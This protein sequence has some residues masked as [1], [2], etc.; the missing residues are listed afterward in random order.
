MI[1]LLVST[2]VV[3]EDDEKWVIIKILKVIII[4]EFF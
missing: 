1:C 2:A 3:K 4:L